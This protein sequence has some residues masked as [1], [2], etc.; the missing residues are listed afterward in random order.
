MPVDGKLTTHR[1]VIETEQP[2]AETLDR[3]IELAQVAVGGLATF[4]DTTTLLAHLRVLR[5][6]LALTEQDAV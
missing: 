2:L 4:I 5:E 1:A 3:C 6:D